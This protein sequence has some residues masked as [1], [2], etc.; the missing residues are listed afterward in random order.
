MTLKALKIALNWIV[1]IDGLSNTIFLKKGI[2]YLFHY[3]RYIL[4]FSH[5]RGQSLFSNHHDNVFYSKQSSYWESL[6]SC[7]LSDWPRKAKRFPCEVKHFYLNTP[8]GTLDC[9]TD[10]SP[11]QILITYFKCSPFMCQPELEF[12]SMA[13]LPLTFRK[14]D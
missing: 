4:I 2:I 14:K 13:K 11:N 7:P 5:I 8:S 1:E 12:K 3:N 10:H 6:I 9:K